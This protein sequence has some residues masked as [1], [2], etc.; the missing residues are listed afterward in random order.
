MVPCPALKPAAIP[1]LRII[2]TDPLPECRSAN[3]RERRSSNPAA[4]APNASSKR[5]VTRVMR[6]RTDTSVIRW[7]VT[8]SKK[9]RW[10]VHQTRRLGG[11]VCVLRVCLLRP[12]E[13]SLQFGHQV[14][15]VCVIVSCTRPPQG[16]ISKFF[17]V[18]QSCETRTC[19]RLSTF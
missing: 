14:D 13:L 15:V 6:V 17:L 1:A 19:P 2:T 10:H 18:V 16:C 3:G 7:V 12:S 8:L 9:A 4:R 5:T 11:I